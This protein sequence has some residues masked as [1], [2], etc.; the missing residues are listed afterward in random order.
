MVFLQSDVEAEDVNIQL[1]D[2]E[3]LAF[4]SGVLVSLGTDHE[5]RLVH[6]GVAHFNQ[7]VSTHVLDRMAI[8]IEAHDL[9][10]L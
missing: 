3:G 8:A 4:A 5:E 1:K 6:V 10:I 2:A 7:D 9:G